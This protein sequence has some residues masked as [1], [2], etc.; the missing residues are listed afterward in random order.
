MGN[1]LYCE[2]IPAASPL[3]FWEHI[4]FFVGIMH[5]KVKIFHYIF[6]KILFIISHSIMVHAH[7]G[8]CACE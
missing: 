4:S 8:V 1:P 3:H 5:M 2:A 7:I 6:I